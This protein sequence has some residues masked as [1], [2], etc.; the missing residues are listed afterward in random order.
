MKAL[1]VTSIGDPEAG[2]IG[3]LEIRDIPIPEPEPEEVRIKV[4]Y[5]S[6]CGSDGH[7]LRGNLGPLRPL[8][9]ASLPGRLGH[10]MSGIVDKLGEKAAQVTGLKPG[11]RITANFAHYCNSCY[12]CRSGKENYCQ[13][14]D[15]RQNAMS[16]YICWHMTQ[17]YKIPDGI[18]LLDASQT[19]PLSIALNAVETAQVKLGSRVVV[20]GCGAIGLMAVQ[21][22]KLAGAS[23]VASI[24]I[25]AS[26]RE[27]ALN[28]GADIA[29]DPSEE[30]WEAKAIEWTG[31]LG[32]DAAIESSGASS[33]AQSA[34][35]LIG[36]DG[37]AV[38]FAM[39][40]PEFELK[41]NLFM[42][43]YLKQKHIHGMYTS[44]DCFPKTIALLPRMNLKPIIQGLYSL[45]E[46]AKAMDDQLSGKFAKLAFKIAGE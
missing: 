36:V 41:V 22:A 8:A 46:C 42:E 6:I 28:T 20:F 33:A 35:Q 12:F 44:A 40:N 5:A 9:E 45:D 39:Y 2:K 30:G 3:T 7:I 11:D 24:D 14:T 15:S 25:V 38:F 27:I 1:Y 18:S 13:H 19:E 43:M 31:G 17:I 23:Q 16:E 37:H 4:A 26:K 29:F 34:I 32:F 21:V 10:E